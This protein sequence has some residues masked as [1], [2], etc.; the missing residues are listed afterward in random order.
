M[1]LFWKREVVLIEIVDTLID[2][3]FFLF[4]ETEC[5]RK[6]KLRTEVVERDME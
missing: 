4:R 2:S 3:R 6:V 1:K 5:S